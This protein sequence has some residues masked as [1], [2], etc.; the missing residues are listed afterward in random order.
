MRD[1]GT[2]QKHAMHTQKPHV[3]KNKLQTPENCDLAQTTSNVCK[4]QRINLKKYKLINMIEE[5][6]YLHSKTSQYLL[7]K[8]IPLLFKYHSVFAKD[9]E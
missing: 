3:C 6:N 2:K 5:I 7:H 9:M 1:D 8:D 4:R